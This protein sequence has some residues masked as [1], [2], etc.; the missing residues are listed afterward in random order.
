[1]KLNPLPWLLI[2]IIL[3][4]SWWARRQLIEE[5]QLAFFC[6]GGGQS[7]ACEAHRWLV[8]IFYNSNAMG[9]VSLLLGG[10]AVLTR[11]GRLGL[12]TGVIGIV[13]LV[14][15]N[16]EYA[17]IGFLLGA[18]TLARSQFDASR[19]QHRPSQ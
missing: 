6:E 12:L 19:A 5:Q 4:V 16:A 3:C 10:L 14:L 18:L 15:H 8:S 2:L 11:S 9:Y 7:L 13:S 17:A 1:M